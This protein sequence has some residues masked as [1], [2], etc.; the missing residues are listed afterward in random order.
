[1]LDVRV[2]ERSHIEVELVTVRGAVVE[3]GA[4]RFAVELG[5]HLVEDLLEAE[6]VRQ[7]QSAVVAPVVA[8]EHVHDRRLGADR[9]QRG[10][11]VDHPASGVETG[12]RDAEEADL[13]VVP[14]HLLQQPFD[15]IEGVAALIHFRR[16][17]LGRLVRAHIDERTFGVHPPA[18]VLIHEDVPRLQIERRG[19]EAIPVVV[20]PVW[21]DPVWGAVHQHRVGL[22][23]VLRRIDDGE[24]LDA[25]PHRDLVLALR[26]V[27]E[28]V[29]LEGLRLV[30]SIRFGGQGDRP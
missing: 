11:G 7:Q 4:A 12:V 25:V 23:R 29:L 28:D 16:L 6:V 27:R 21:P 24:K 2:G 20:D 13:A 30:G 3:L 26:V 5:R 14:R 10:V 8:V 19:A 17:G 15:G 1:M 9:F 18:D 22:L